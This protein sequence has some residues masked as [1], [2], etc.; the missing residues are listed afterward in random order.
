MRLCLTLVSA[1]S[2]VLWTS[3]TF[4]QA[5][6]WTKA[7]PDAGDWFG[8]ANWS[9]GVPSNHKDAE[10]SNGGTATIAS[11]VATPGQVTLGRLASH[12]GALELQGGTL[13]IEASSFHLFVGNAGQGT[14]NQSNGTCAFTVATQMYLGYQATGAGTYVLSGSTNTSR[15]LYTGQQSL[16][17]N[18]MEVIGYRG[19][20]TFIQS[21][22]RNSP[23]DRAIQL[24]YLAGSSGTYS[25]SG[26]FLSQIHGLSSLVI[27]REGSGTFIQTGGSVQNSGTMTLAASAT[28]RGYYELSGGGLSTGRLNIGINGGTAEFNHLSG[29]HSS[30][31]PHIGATGRYTFW[32]GTLTVGST[33]G[34]T[35]DAGGEFTQRGGQLLST[36]GAPITND[37]T[38][39]LLGGTSS[40]AYIQGDGT[41]SVGASASPLV[42][43][44]RQSA[45]L[46]DGTLTIRR[47]NQGGQTSSVGTL[48]LFNGSLDLADNDLLITST[49]QSLVTGFIREAR[50]GGAWDH[51]GITSSSARDSISHNTTLGLMDGATYR[52]LNGATATFGGLPVDDSNVLVKYTYYG[53]A[54][55][56]GVVDFDDYSRTDSGFN[57]GQTGWFHGDFD[58][59]GIVDFDDY[60]LIDL[61]F[62]TQSGTMLRALSYLDGTDRSLRGMDAPP[63][64]MVALH[65]A[66]FGDVYANSFLNAVPE[67]TAVVVVPAL[68]GVCRRPRRRHLREI[69]RACVFQ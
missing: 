49:S 46:L 28:G 10:V 54:D 15:M 44:A 55:F 45:M 2:V 47:S 64:R 21:G 1:L 58:Y 9:S 29:S 35:V 66:Q 26:G 8:A 11:G 65:Y 62:N 57:S 67:P 25:M 12:S 20:G 36:T 41:T 38:I 43:F 48:T 56:N 37:G 17:P 30:G 24:G 34:L 3:F 59:S 52:A 40:L 42:N 7:P 68:A 39:N 19:A 61:A 13:S 33:S 16:T 27:G 60:S 50:N 5:S 22:G 31:I 4:G 32:D 6:V 51:A 14:V 69:P 18:D 23:F 53:D 63:L